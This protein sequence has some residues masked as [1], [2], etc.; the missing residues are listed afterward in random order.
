MESRFVPFRG[1][2]RA[3]DEELALTELTLG[4]R[5]TVGGV[6]S[7]NGIAD[8]IL[9]RFGLESKALAEKL[10]LSFDLFSPRPGVSL[11]SQLAMSFLS[12]VDVKHFS[13][14]FAMWGWIPLTT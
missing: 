9:I 2:L 13:C 14:L 11:L 5:F 4:D 12:G 8:L 7:G 3:F 10:E 1:A 6:V